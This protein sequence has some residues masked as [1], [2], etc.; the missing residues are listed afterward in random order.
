MKHEQWRILL[1]DD[2]EDDYI[3]TGD[4]LSE[5]EGN[6]FNLDWV[7]TYEAALTAMQHNQ[8]DLY[9]VDYRL[10]AHDGLE[11]L[12][13]ATA[14]GCRGPIILLTGLGND[15]IGGKAIE[16]GAVDYLIKGKFDAPRLEHSIR[17]AIE[18]NNIR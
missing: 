11:L 3:I 2:D 16:A 9:L 13:Q 10:G 8:Y 17:Q 12:H 5:I 7:P 6:A 4:I 18:R 14:D 1:V 15:T